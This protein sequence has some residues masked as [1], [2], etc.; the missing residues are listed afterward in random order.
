MANVLATLFQD[1]ASEIKAKQGVGDDVKYKPAEFP[2]QIASIQT[3]SGEEILTGVPIELDFSDGAT[4]QTITA[5]DGTLVKSAVIE[6]P[7]TLIPEN[8]A[9]D[10]TIAGIIGTLTGGGGESDILLPTTEMTFTEN[11]DYGNMWLSAPALCELEVGKKYVVTWDGVEY[12]CVGIDLSAMME[13]TVAI[14]NLAFVGGDDTGEPFAFAYEPGTQADGVVYDSNICLTGD[15]DTHY[16]KIAK[17]PKTLTVKTGTFRASASPHTATHGMGFVPD[18][19]IVWINK[20]L[21]H[22]KADMAVGFS[23]AM[24]EALGEGKWSF[25]RNAIQ[26]G[27]NMN[28]G[29]VNA[30]TG[31]EGTEGN[32]QGMIREVNSSTFKVGGDT[33]MYDLIYTSDY[34][35]MA[36]GGITG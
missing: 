34:N 26:M 6:K 7:D 16:I 12:T 25:L 11:P 2:E 29:T 20:P 24:Y 30:S 13:G 18:I 17:A 21:E 27:E 31:F 35:W 22:L 4:S 15:T 3:G 19:I 32:M 23:N 33:G 36:I 1:I 8:I 9:K 14:G 5:P 10:V 28:V